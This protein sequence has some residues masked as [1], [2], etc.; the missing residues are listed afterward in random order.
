MAGFLI[1]TNV[2]VYSYDPGN[3]TKRARA[4]DVLEALSVSGAAFST[5]ILGEFFATVTRKIREPLSA[6]DAAKQVGLFIESSDVFDVTVSV[7]IEALRGVIDHQLPY[8]D[9]LIW[10][11]AHLN[12]IATI[13]T[14]DG[15]HN[16]LIEGVRY[17][18]PFHPDFD[19]QV[20]EQ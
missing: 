13:L 3:N 17:L 4:H 1:D 15:Q 20:F 8:Y 16:R 7:V 2:L 5:Q 19:L 14:E 9:A 18:N 6:K 11:T 10:A 12:Q